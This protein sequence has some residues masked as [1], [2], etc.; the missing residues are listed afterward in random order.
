MIERITQLFSKSKKIIAAVG[1]I[2][3]A[4][5][6]LDFNNRVEELFRLSAERNMMTTQVAELKGTESV[7]QT[8]IAYANSDAAA[9][10]WARE[11]AFMARPGDEPIIMLPDP[12]FTPQPT[13]QLIFTPVVVSNWQVWGLLFFGE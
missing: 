5:L 4:F 11:E 3:L 2:F 9:E 7:M 6:I 10:K 13:P 12:N 1:L 8:R